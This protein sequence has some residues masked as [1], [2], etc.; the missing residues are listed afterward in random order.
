[1]EPLSSSD[2]DRDWAML[3]D[4]LLVQIF[5]LLRGVEYHDPEHTQPQLVKL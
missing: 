3:P 1:M 2:V 4:V 5:V